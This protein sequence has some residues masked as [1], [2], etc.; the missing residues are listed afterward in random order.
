MCLAFNIT[1]L[2]NVFLSSSYW[3][4]TNGPYKV[5]LHYAEIYQGTKEPGQ[6]VFDVNI[7]GTTV[8]DNFDIASSV[9]PFKATTQVA[10]VNV[11]DGSLEITFG[12]VVQNPKVSEFD[13]I[14]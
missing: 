14:P 11:Q 9:G 4:V 10:T 3:A 12:K 8:V 2:N 13:D 5:T 7:E 1:F 6:R